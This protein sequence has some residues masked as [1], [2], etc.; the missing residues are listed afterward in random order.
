MFRFEYDDERLIKLCHMIHEC[1][2]VV[3]MTGGI[4]NLFPSIRYIAPIL[5]GYQPLLDAH[6]PLWNFL[7]EV[8][9][10]SSTNRYNEQ[11]KSFIQSY[12]DELYKKY[13]GEYVHESFSGMY[14]M[15][16]KR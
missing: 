4:L 9:T 7:C 15:T 8:V 3:D 1:F 6:K 14:R 5:S 10:E 2:R 13:N 11:T 16:L 12:L